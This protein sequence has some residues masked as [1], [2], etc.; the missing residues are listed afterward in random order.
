MRDLFR[1]MHRRLQLRGWIAL[2]LIVAGAVWLPHVL[3]NFLRERRAAFN[4][5]RAQA[6]L[7]SGRFDVAR[8]KFR[9]ALRLKPGNA[10][11]HRQLAAMELRLDQWELAFLELQ[12]LT[13]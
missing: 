6:H 3:P 13:E 4:L 1:L 9:A 12:A 2:C 8:A 7:A 5:K 10:E 11:A